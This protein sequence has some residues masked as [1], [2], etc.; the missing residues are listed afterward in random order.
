M[1]KCWQT[2]TD[3]EWTAGRSKWAQLMAVGVLARL[4]I[5]G[6]RVAGHGVS[7]CLIYLQVTQFKLLLN[8]LAALLHIALNRGIFP[9]LL[10]E[11]GVSPCLLAKR[12]VSPCVQVSLLLVSPAQ[13][14]NCDGAGRAGPQCGEALWNGPL[15]GDWSGAGGQR[16]GKIRGE[17]L[18][19]CT[20]DHPLA[21]LA[22]M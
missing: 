16:P 6:S 15:C 21:L 17:Y 8:A 19:H 20:A 3:S 22:V 12:G 10:A 4:P 18:S 1:I 7:C 11:Q 14:P 9:C 2:V 13:L 5:T